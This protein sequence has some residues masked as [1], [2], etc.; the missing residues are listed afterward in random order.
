MDGYVV[1]MAF[2]TAGCAPLD[3]LMLSV[4]FP[5]SPR[6]S[7]RRPPI[8]RRN[9]LR[10]RREWGAVA[11]KRLLVSKAGL[12]YFRDERIE[13]YYMRDLCGARGSPFFKRP[14]TYRAP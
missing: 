6:A 11:R 5:F 1:A 4:V 10:L 2:R 14:A 12:F 3:N 8:E 13:F 9:N 7:V